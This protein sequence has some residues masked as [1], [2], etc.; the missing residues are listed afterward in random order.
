MIRNENDLFLIDAGVSAKRVRTGLEELGYDLSSVRAIFLTHEHIDHIRGLE[1]LYH[2]VSIPLYAPAACFPDIRKCAPAASS[3]LVPFNPGDSA[4]LQSTRLFA[5]RTPH[6]AMGS[7]GFRIACAEEA[8]AYFTDIGHLTEEV[9][10]A[11]SDCRRVVIESN[12]DHALLE[13]GPYPLA[14]KRRIDG[15][16]GHL[17]NRECASLLPHLLRH[18]TEKILLA[19]LSEQNNTPEIA[20]HTCAAHLP[21]PSCV[22]ISSPTQTVSL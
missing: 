6:D 10:R 20:F 2:S 14:L 9:V 15:P 4:C 21:D 19:H 7:V 16:N 11:M 5:V 1:T 3:F 12:Y 18:G 13:S 22:T 8:I 17:S